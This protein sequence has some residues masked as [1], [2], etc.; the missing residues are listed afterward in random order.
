MRV[1]LAGATGVI[2]TPL[3]PQLLE[4]GHEVTAMTRSVLRAAQL[5]AGWRGPRRVRRV[6]CRR[7]AGGHGR[8]V[9]TGGHPPAHLA[10][11]A[12]RLEQARPARRQQPPADRG[13]PDP[14][15]CGAWQRRAPYGGA[16]HRVRIRAGRRPRQGGGGSAVHRRAAA[17]RRRGQG[18]RRARAAGHGHNGHRGSRVALRH[19][20]RARHLLRP[21]RLQRGRRQRGPRAAHRGRHRHLQL[22]ARRGRRLSGRRRAPARRT[23]RLQRRRR[24]AGAAA[25]VAARPRARAARRSTPRWRMCGPHR[26]R[27]RCRC[28]ARPT[29]GPSASSD[30][31]RTKR[32]GAKASPPASRER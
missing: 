28:A 26:K 11:D 4:A 17:T 8:C 23:G 21:A 22:A 15:R 27:S 5:E 25:R 13:D 16:E 20:L 24:R 7:G 14:P 1:F 6:R 3:V 12:A 31:G 19:A 30:G 18:G 29:P 10:A 32:A 2:G 9:A